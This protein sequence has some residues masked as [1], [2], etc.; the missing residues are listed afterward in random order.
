[1]KAVVMAGGFGTRIQPLTSSL[2]KPML[3]VLNRPMMG[4]VVERLKDAGI[5]EIIILL[6]FKPDIIQSYF[7]DGTDFGV[8][9]TY[10]IPEEDYGTA[11]AVKQAAPYLDERFMVISGDL[12][13]D[14]NLRE[15]IGFHAANQARATITLTSVEDPLQFGVV[16]TDKKNQIIR[17]LEKP[18][19]GEVFSD[20]INTGIY[21]F[22]PEILSFIPDNVPF[23]F[24]KD[25]FPK[26]MA[27]QIS[28]FGYNARGYWRDVGNPNSYRDSLV[29]ILE[30]KMALPV[31]GLREKSF[32]AGKLFYEQEVSLP[33]DISVTGRV[34][35]GPEVTISE[36]VHLENCAIGAASIIGKKTRITGSIL[37]DHVSVGQNCQI[38]NSVL[39]NLV[40]FGHG[41]HAEHGCIIAENTDVGSHVVFEKDVMVWPDKQIEEESIV[42][43]NLIWGDKWKKTIFEGGKVSARTNV[44]LSA[45]L[46]AKL[47]TAFGSI[48]PKG[49]NVLLSRDYHRASR[50]LKRGF[51]SGLLA[52]G[53]NGVDL[54]MVPTP[55]MRFILA[56]H[57]ELFGVHFRQSP[58]DAT[59]TEIFFYGEDGLPISTN[60][61]KGIER[62]F[63]R[64]NFRRVPQN[65]VGI[66]TSRVD[67]VHRYQSNFFAS[68]DKTAIRSRNFR[69]VLDLL[70]GTTDTI[71]PAILNELNIES[72]V[73]NAY[74]DERKLSRSPSKRNSSLNQCLNIVKAVEADLGLI[75]QPHGE[76]LQIISDKGELLNREQALLLFLRLIDMTVREPVKVY[77]PVS[78]PDMIDAQLT[79]LEIVRGKTAD[80]KKEFLQQFYFCSPG[81]D[82]Y[83]FPHLHPVK[84][85][86]FSAVKLLEMLAVNETR[87]SAIIDSL[88]KY[89]FAHNVINCPLEKKGFLMRRMSEEAVDK[90]ASFIDGIKIYADRERWVL[91]VPD[92][93]SPNAHLYVQSPDRETGEEMMES[94]K[95]MIGE[96]LEE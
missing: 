88:P 11:G 80:L 43:S 33:D 61:E 85:G 60:I 34:V 13:T 32:P 17:F 3:P 70:N 29:D 96:W 83:G 21:V 5:T 9:I 1:M 91:M 56:N 44:E 95:K 47:G 79:R 74:Q 53:I 20:T 10:V 75:L 68:V 46:S 7:G 23:D 73:L 66:I 37:W 41:I 94:Y 22:E 93:Y 52:A 77:L 16:I 67:L 12:I 14:F 25:L 81:G 51:L 71:F 87:V 72:T 89:Y 36:G 27:D 84:D 35:L 24:S 86:M 4:Y 38:K 2:P 90:R 55:I 76:C 8:K 15:I 78:T 62:F 54:K 64:E 49:C 40:N 19:W 42:S 30:D 92:Q 28:I 48:A 26:L 50:M 31:E 45:E 18:G 6:Y 39:C 58:R 59:V 65:E 63:F 69:L 57:R 82:C